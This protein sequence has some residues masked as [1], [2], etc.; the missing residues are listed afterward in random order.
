MKNLGETEKNALVAFIAMKLMPLLF[1]PKNDGNFAS[2]QTASERFRKM[3]LDVGALASFDAD[4]EGLIGASENS[5]DA[6]DTL[7]YAIGQHLIRRPTELLPFLAHAWL[8]LFLLGE[9]V[10][11]PQRKQ[12]RPN[13]IGKK[14][15]IWRILLKLKEFGINPTRNDATDAATNPSGCDLVAEALSRLGEKPKSYDAVKR[16]WNEIH[17]DT[18]SKSATG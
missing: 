12:G 1:G 2:A 10:A 4:L 11:P 7:K 14:L 9:I 16:I 13:E 6:Y 17:N 5:I 3:Q 15:M 8:S 18:K